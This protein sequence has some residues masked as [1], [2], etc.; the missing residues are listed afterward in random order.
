VEGAV[1]DGVVD[2]DNELWVGGQLISQQRL[3]AAGRV[4]QITVL[5]DA[6][7]LG[8]RTCHVRYHLQTPTTDRSLSSHR[9][10][11]TSAIMLGTTYCYEKK[12][13]PTRAP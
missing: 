8:Q 7:Q 5:G 4:E 1:S 13:S 12:P 6:S 10:T 11:G 9:W 2:V 3:D